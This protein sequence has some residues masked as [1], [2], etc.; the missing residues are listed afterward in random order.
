ML[1]LYGKKRSPI[2]GRPRKPYSG[3][4]AGGQ[5]SCRGCGV[6][7]HPIHCQAGD[8]FVVFLARRL[9]DFLDGIFLDQRAV[10]WYVMTGLMCECRFPFI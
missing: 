7:D 10:R 9:R 2:G 8:A 4:G 3:P 5:E 6:S 1:S